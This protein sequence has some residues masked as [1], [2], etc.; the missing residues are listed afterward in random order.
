MKESLKIL[1]PRRISKLIL[2]CVSLVALFFDNIYSEEYNLLDNLGN[3]FLKIAEY[4]LNLNIEDVV[5][6]VSASAVMYSLINNDGYLKDKINANKSSVLDT[7]SSIDI[8]GDGMFQLA[9][10]GLMHN[11][12]GKK[13]KLVARQIV[14]SIIEAG[15]ISTILKILTGRNRP[16]SGDNQYAF[17]G[18]SFNYDSSPSGH[19]TLAFTV[20]TVVG[21]AYDCGYITYPLATLVGFS[22]IYKEAHWASDVFVG[23][24]LGIGIGKLHKID[25]DKE[26]IGF[27]LNLN[28]EIPVYGISYKF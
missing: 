13:E 27:F 6:L 11:I 9:G 4:P 22:R 17:Y 18:P 3:H 19:T 8:L 23:V 28:N 24:L 5:V 7:L 12:G 20:A 25:Y 15:T 16:S 14:E 26:N 1:K 2:L 10:C 21:D